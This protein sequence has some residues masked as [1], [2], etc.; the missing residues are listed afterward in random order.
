MDF[1]SYPPIV[2]RM[3]ASERGKPMGPETIAKRSGLSRSTV[4]RVSAASWDEVRIGTARKFIAGCGFKWGSTRNISRKARALE[5]VGIAGL[6]HLNPDSKKPLW[7]RGASGN[8][9][10][11]VIRIIS[12]Q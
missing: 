6:K 7:R 12:Q 10:K 11:F 3:L 8:T 5:G 1:L 9:R 2:Y 4:Q